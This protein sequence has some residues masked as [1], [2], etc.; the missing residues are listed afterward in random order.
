MTPSTKKSLIW[1][2]VAVVAIII[3]AF[4]SNKKDAPI[5]VTPMPTPEVT[6]LKDDL[7]SFSIALKV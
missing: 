7:V 6:G 2:L 1:L 5:V 4:M 3:L